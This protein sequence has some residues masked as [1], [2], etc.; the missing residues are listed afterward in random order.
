[1][2]VNYEDPFFGTFTLDRRIDWFTGSTIWKGCAVALHLSA[3]APAKVQSALTTAHSL[4]QTQDLPRYQQSE[5][6]AQKHG[7]HDLELFCAV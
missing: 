1:M 5:H 3:R 2:P 4:L 7:S 6:I